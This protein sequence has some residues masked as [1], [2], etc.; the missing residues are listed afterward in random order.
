ME[1]CLDL[2][3]AMPEGTNP[4][5]FLRWNGEGQELVMPQG[6]HASP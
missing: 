6:L 2:A 3:N 5:Q 4:G 1:A